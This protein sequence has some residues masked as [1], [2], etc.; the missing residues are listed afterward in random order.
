MCLILKGRIGIHQANKMCK[1][2]RKI[3]WREKGRR[4]GKWELENLGGHISK[5]EGFG[6]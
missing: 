5:Q 4:A 1:V 3:G 2:C 6:I